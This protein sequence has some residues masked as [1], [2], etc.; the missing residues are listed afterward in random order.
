VRALF[1]GILLLWFCDSRG[2][3]I[4]VKIGLQ[5]TG[6]V[7]SLIFTAHS[8]TYKLLADGVPVIDITRDHLVQVY[9]QNDSLY[10]KN[11]GT[12][13]TRARSILFQQLYDSCVFKLKCVT[14]NVAVKEFNGSLQIDPLK[15]KMQLVNVVAL[16]HYV[17]GV[18]ES[19][20]GI[21]STP[22]YYKTQAILC[23]TY[24][25][26]HLRRHEEEGYNLCDMVHCQA[27]KRRS[28]GNEII[29]KSTFATNN[30]VLV[31]ANLQLI[32]A[33]F[34]S[35]CGG[36]TVNS[37]EV[38]NKG[39]PYLR[40]IRD[41]FCY[42]QPNAKWRKEMPLNQW[43]Q[44]LDKC[45]FPVTDSA[46]C[47]MSCN[48]IQPIRLAYLGDVTT[49]VPL[50]NIRTDLNLRSTFFSVQQNDSTIVLEGKGY[51]HGVG[52]CQEG[53]MKMSRLGYNYSKILHFY[54][55]NVNIVNLNNL[56]FFK[57]N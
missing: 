24:G 32:T 22:E 6:N 19:E 37:E 39:L 45:K 26:T 4:D 33:A 56:H 41:T 10:I 23:R 46:Y 40:S 15:K 34:H 44:Y 50:K 17:A 51:G 38:W 54:F 42:T 31:D 20:V 16:E 47:K 27:Y 36:Q 9:L 7:S 49:N 28:K 11:E 52:L 18:V 13:I 8:G 29:I 55:Q 30:L 12:I 25:L 57:E 14:P 1:I 21:K 3:I 48:L 35:N 43:L 53:A 2:E 5:S